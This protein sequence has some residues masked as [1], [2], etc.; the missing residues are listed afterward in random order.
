[1]A[2]LDDHSDN[3]NVRQ[4]CTQG[5]TESFLAK[6]VIPLNTM[7]AACHKAYVPSQYE[8][9]SLDLSRAKIVQGIY[10]WVPERNEFGGYSGSRLISSSSHGRGAF[11]ATKLVLF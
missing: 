1:M 2:H 10:R 7:K 5:V 6:G 4:L 9:D 11:T 3:V 8:S